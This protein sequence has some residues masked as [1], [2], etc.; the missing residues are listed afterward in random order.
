MK[1]HL[2]LLLVFICTNLNAQK[3]W[4]TGK[5]FLKD[6]TI[7]EGLITLPVVTANTISLNGKEKV[8][9]KTD[10]QSKKKKKYFEKDIDSL[11][12]NS[13]RIYKFI[14]I[15]KAKKSLCLLVKEGSVTLYSRSVAMSYSNG[16][17]TGSGT[18]GGW[19]T[20][21]HS[22]NYPQEY[23]AIR[24]D[25]QIASPLVKYGP[26]GVTFRRYVLEYF[27]DCEQLTTK[28]KNKIYKKENIIDIVAEYDNCSS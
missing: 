5:I 17:H 23:Y 11:V 8:K 18:Q 7:K 15:S 1:I 20:K 21:F 4:Q 16:I 22:T 19:V 14:A 12:L 2:T 10:A 9:Y 26:F 3:D 27:K 6:G 25:E 24:A 28:I 13:N